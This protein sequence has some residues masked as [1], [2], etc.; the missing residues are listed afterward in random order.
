VRQ[1]IR[2]GRVRI[3]GKDQ[4]MAPKF[5]DGV[6]PRPARN[7]DRLRKGHMNAPKSQRPTGRRKQQGA[8]RNARESEIEELN[9]CA[10]KVQAMYRGHLARTG[11]KAKG[12]KIV[13]AKGGQAKMM[14]EKAKRSSSKGKHKAKG[15]KGK[16]AAKS[17]KAP[18]PLP[19]W[20]LHVVYFLTVRMLLLLS[21]LLCRRCVYACPHHV[22]CGC[23]C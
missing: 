2:E 20:F 10:S 11:R 19:Y 6:R 4:P 14:R 1:A 12:G 21:L 7:T 9:R 16:M 5:E 13:N 15:P 18:P 23:S 22:T 8:R 3:G 17:K